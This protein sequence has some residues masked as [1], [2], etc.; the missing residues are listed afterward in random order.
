MSSDEQNDLLKDMNLA[1]DRMLASE[2]DEHGLFDE[3]DDYDQMLDE[4]TA[5]DVEKKSVP[6]Q[7]TDVIP[8]PRETD[9]EEKLVEAIKKRAQEIEA[10]FAE[11]EKE[12]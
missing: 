11:E 1:A 3:E 8:V 10:L 12:E 5:E 6:A 2:D 7:A 9:L 4:L